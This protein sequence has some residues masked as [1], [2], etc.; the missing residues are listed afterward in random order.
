MAYKLDLPDSSHLHP[1]FH[2]SQLKEFLPRETIP[3]QTLPTVR[4]A[5]QVPLSILQKR[6]RSQGK[7]TI[8]QGLDHLSE[9]SPADATWEDLEHLKQQ[10]PRAPAWG[11]AGSQGG[12]IVSD[13][14]AQ[15]TEDHHQAATEPDTVHHLTSEEVTAENQA[16]SGPAARPTRVKMKPRWN[17]GPE[18]VR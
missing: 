14:R 6:V 18:W 9:S 3:S 7:R 5:I 1:V 4:A 13:T 11:Q 15:D 10:F 16:S 8:A 12:R 2:V 17:G